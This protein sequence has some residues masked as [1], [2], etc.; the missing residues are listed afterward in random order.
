[1]DLRLDGYVS[2]SMPLV[3]P[4]GGAATVMYIIKISE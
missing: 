1:M 4:D 2:S 3:V